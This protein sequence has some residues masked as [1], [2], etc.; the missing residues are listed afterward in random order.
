MSQE[1]V[2]LVR[3]NI[4]AINKSIKNFLVEMNN[5]VILDLKGLEDL[6]K[7]TCSEVESMKKE[8][9][10]PLR[11]EFEDSLSRVRELRDF[12]SQEL[13]S[14]SSKIKDANVRKSAAQTYMRVANDN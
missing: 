14:T 13:E 7:I 12:L 11:A 9:F 6:V 1:K 10:D 2:S 4:D 3:R 8:D 5:G